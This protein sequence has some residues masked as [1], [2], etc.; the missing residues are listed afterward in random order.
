VKLK[1]PAFTLGF[2]ENRQSQRWF[3]TNRPLLRMTTLGSWH[4]LSAEYGI[5][6]GLDI[7]ELNYA[8]RNAHNGTLGFA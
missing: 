5:T 2:L 1:A 3:C 4:V 6:E 8:I 7:Y